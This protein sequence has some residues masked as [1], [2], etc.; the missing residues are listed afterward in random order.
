VIVFKFTAHAIFICAFNYSGSVTEEN[1]INYDFNVQ[2]RCT[3]I[4]E[5]YA[6]L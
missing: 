1:G 6:E 4:Q 3:L 5:S 2:S